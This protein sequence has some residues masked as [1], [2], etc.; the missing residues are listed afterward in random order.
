MKSRISKFLLD[1]VL[2]PY[3]LCKRLMTKAIN[4]VTK[5]I[6]SLIHSG[7]QIA[8]KRPDWVSRVLARPFLF[9]PAFAP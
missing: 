6:I 9:T 1:W 5:T 3:Q 4:K 8:M 7:L 2:L